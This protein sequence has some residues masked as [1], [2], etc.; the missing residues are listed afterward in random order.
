[1]LSRMNDFLSAGETDKK[2]MDIEKQNEFLIRMDEL[3]STCCED[4]AASGKNVGVGSFLIF[5]AYS[6]FL[7][8]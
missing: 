3:L 8:R 5:I 6:A 1:L 7:V 2:D 4:S